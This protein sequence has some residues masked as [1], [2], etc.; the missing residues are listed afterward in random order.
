MRI[1]KQL[2]KQLKEVHFGG[3]WTASD[4]KKQLNDVNW[5]EANIQIYSCNSIGTLVYHMNYYIRTVT[6]VLQGHSLESKDSESFKHP[7]IDSAETW[8]KAQ[9]QFFEEAR[10]FEA[11]LQELP[12]DSLWEDFTDQK[13]GHYYRNLMG[14][15]EHFYYHLGQIA[16]IKKIIKSDH[17]S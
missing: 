5:K 12:E 7:P 14:I 3:N 16:L 9:R 2:A 8:S 17:W 15:I 1:T 10:I 6:R 4:L 11:L 13:Y